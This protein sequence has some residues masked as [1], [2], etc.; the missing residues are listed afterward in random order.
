M[1]LIAVPLSLSLFSRCFYSYGLLF[2]F[3]R[4]YLTV[5]KT[6]ALGLAFYG[7]RDRGLLSVVFDAGAE[8]TRAVEGS[9]ISIDDR[10]T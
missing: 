4:E 10:S 1:I 5:K 7:D 8:S 3:L 6:W 2:S 9:I